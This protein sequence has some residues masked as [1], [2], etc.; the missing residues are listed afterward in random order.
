MGRVQQ[1]VKQIKAA[2]SDAN[3]ILYANDMIITPP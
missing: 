3:P 2:K 1:P